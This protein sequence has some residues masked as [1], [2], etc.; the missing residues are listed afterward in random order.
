MDNYYLYTH[1]MI[2]IKSNKNLDIKK[3][4]TNSEKSCLFFFK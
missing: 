1:K 2:K 3:T 4:R